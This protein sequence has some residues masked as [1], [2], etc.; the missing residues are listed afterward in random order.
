M[1]YS[2]GLLCCP[3]IQAVIKKLLVTT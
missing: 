1:D 3:N 2:S